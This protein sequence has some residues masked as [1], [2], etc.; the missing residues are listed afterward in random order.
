MNTNQNQDLSSLSQP[1]T[2]YSKCYIEK[3]KSS[4]ISKEDLKL[5]CQKLT[6]KANEAADKEITARKLPDNVRNAFTS[7]KGKLWVQ[8]WG[9]NDEYISGDH[10]SIFDDHR[11]PKKI[12]R[13]MFNSYD[14]Y[15]IVSQSTMHNWLEIQFDF[16]KTMIFDFSKI[17]DQSNQNNSYV[18]VQGTDETWVSGVYQSIKE[19]IEDKKLSRNWLYSSFTYDALLYLLFFPLVFRSAYLIGERLGLSAL[20]AA[21]MVA[22]YIYIF[23]ISLYLIRF[24]FNYTKWLFPLIEVENGSSLKQRILLFA[25]IIAVV[26]SGL[27]DLLKLLI[28]YI[29]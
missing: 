10:E 20:P 18:K 22:I 5:L 25:I 23:I 1:F 27:Y 29:F 14:G 24:L 4:L 8:I 21:L 19:F 28:R 26:G 17:S 7:L 16:K 11:L 12:I 15:Q 13:I 9:E 6:L 2:H 3:I